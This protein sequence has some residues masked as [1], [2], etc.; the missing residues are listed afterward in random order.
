MTDRTNKDNPTGLA[1][2]FKAIKDIFALQTKVLTGALPHYGERGRNDEERIGKLLEQVL[3]R[4]YSLGT[5]FIISSHPDLP[6]SSQIDI[7]IH[8]EFYNPPLFR[9]LAANVFPIE[10]VY[11]TVE[12]KADLALEKL[13]EAAT[14]I[15]AIRQ[16]AKRGK[17][18]AS[19][20]TRDA[21]ADAKA[22]LPQGV[23]VHTPSYL[24]PRGYV[25]G[26]D[27]DA[28]TPDSFLTRLGT[29]S[30]EHPTAFLHGVYAIRQDWFFC[31]EYGRSTFQPFIDNGLLAFVSKLISDLQ[32]FPMKPAAFGRYVESDRLKEV[33]KLQ[34]GE[35]SEG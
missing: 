26:Y 2:Y 10:A 29:V 34:E 19:Y 28:T 17:Y 33:T 25:V 18:Y 4:R 24:A 27:A 11:A 5:G 13:R 22:T 7:V 35:G 3:P 20:T 23:E 15:A 32:S 16:M 30:A 31:Q 9:E 6:A 14:A 21:P 8:D 1:A 12:A